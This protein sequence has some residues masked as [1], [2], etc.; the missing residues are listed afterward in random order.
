MEWI[1]LSVGSSIVSE[2]KFVVIVIELEFVRQTSTVVFFECVYARFFFLTRAL[3]NKCHII[4][5]H[6][7]RYENKTVPVKPLSLLWIYF[8]FP[9]ISL[10]KVFILWRILP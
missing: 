4:L 3:I 5:D 7:Y 8:V 6:L 1:I 9:T 2:E 10:T